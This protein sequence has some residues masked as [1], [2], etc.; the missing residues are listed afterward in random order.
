MKARLI[1]P[2]G[3]VHMSNKRN[4]VFRECCFFI[5][6]FCHT[7]QYSVAHWKEAKKHYLI[8]LTVSN[9][10]PF[11]KG[12]SRPTTLHILSR[13]IDFSKRGTAPLKGG[14]NIWKCTLRPFKGH[15]ATLKEHPTSCPDT[16]T[17]GTTPKEDHSSRRVC[18]LPNTA[19]VGR[20]GDAATMSKP[21]STS[22]RN[23]VL[24]K[25]HRS[26]TYPR[27]S[28]HP[29][30][31]SSNTRSP[32]DTN[33]APPVAQAPMWPQSRKKNNKKT[34]SHSA[35]PSLLSFYCL[36]E[37]IIMCLLFFFATG[38]GAEFGSMLMWFAFFCSC[39]LH[40][41][42]CIDCWWT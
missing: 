26:S 1:W 13:N 31:P 11:W 28:E 10:L 7:G 40:L 18:L 9:M 42:A 36:N 14:S 32:A 34:H 41:H 5:E 38:Y 22:R 4:P 37:H 33:T 2:R 19:F 15:G 6:Y 3:R 29:D 17:H 23:C 12:C 30:T 20:Y 16:G 8:V 21:S 39:L 25:G 35:P 24:L 27:Q